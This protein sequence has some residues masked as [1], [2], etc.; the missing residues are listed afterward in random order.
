MSQTGVV[1][2]TSQSVDLIRDVRSRRP[3]NPEE[4]SNASPVRFG[5]H[6][7]FLFNVIRAGAVAI[8]YERF[9]NAR[10]K[11]GPAVIEVGI[12]E[13][14]LNFV[15]LCNDNRGMVGVPFQVHSN[16]VSAVLEAIIAKREL[17]SHHLNERGI[18][19]TTSV[20]FGVSSQ[21]VVCVD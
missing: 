20:S 18:F 19:S 2:N 11:R 16:I 10:S 1:C 4:L 13:Q 17:G 21:A 5:S 8:G 9:R 12:G 14:F 3:S 7:T 15:R 6:G